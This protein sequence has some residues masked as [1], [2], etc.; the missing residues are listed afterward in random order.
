MTIVFAFPGGRPI[1][2]KDESA[3]DSDKTI[4]VTDNKLWVIDLIT[5]KFITT[6]VAGDR[7]IV[8]KLTIDGEEFYDYICDLQAPSTR[9]H[10]QWIPATLDKSNTAR[11]IL[12]IPQP[13][14]MKEGDKIRIY[15]T[16][17]VDPTA[18]DL[19]IY[20]WARQVGWY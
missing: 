1:L 14:I 5:A 4:I 19:Y 13:L 9:V 6:A 20:V 7:R 3:N 11:P 10:Y 17:A 8:L 2:R 18:D 16:N 15:D 12:P